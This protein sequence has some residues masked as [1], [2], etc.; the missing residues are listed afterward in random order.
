MT[1]SLPSS[2]NNY[3]LNHQWNI[4]EDLNTQFPGLRN[5]VMQV[6]ISEEAQTDKLVWKHN[7]TG[8]LSSKEAYEFKKHHFPKLH[9]T[10]HVWF[11]DIPPSKSLMVWRLMLDKLPIDDNLSS[12][13]CHLPSMCSL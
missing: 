5:L 3:I 10:K 6:T 13:G 1:H 12:R 8:D 7:S 11:I 4:S 2:L 9:W